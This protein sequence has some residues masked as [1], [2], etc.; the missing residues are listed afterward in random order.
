MI[1]PMPTTA[2]TSP[3]ANSGAGRMRRARRGA[4][5]KL[6][7]APTIPGTS[8]NPARNG[9]SPPTSCRCWATQTMVPPDS[10]V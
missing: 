2:T 8:A 1:T 10:I 4:S 3:P 5:W 7:M 6:P 9:D